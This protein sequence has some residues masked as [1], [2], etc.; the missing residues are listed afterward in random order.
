VYRNFEFNDPKSKIQLKGY[1]WDLQNPRYV[2][3]IIHGL[4]EL[5]GRYDRMND[6]LAKAGVAS[7][8]MDLRGHGRSGGVRGHCA[9]RKLV[10]G[11]IDRL[12]EKAQELYT[13][14]PMVFYGHS[15]GGN[16]AL[17]YKTRGRLN[18]VPAAYIISAPWLILKE[19]PSAGLLR[20]V[21]VLSKVAPSLTI[22]SAIDER[23]LGHPD[24]VKPYKD[25]P[26]VHDKISMLTAIEGL[27]IGEA[28]VNGTLEDNG[29]S[30]GKPWLLM[31][32]T[33]DK[34]CDIEGSRALY[35]RAPENCTFI[36]WE[37]L[38]H[39]IH[40]GN[41]TSRGD[42]VIEKMVAWIGEL[43]D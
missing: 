10:L 43:K 1:A 31:H 16:I 5:A 32:G 14:V 15:L 42:E 34:I 38:F 28:I 4:G 37:G 36:P 7:V 9:P 18:N 24:S 20:M 39:E 23:I 21:S 17:D 25:N 29:G 13:G 35:K 27:Q 2:M 26:L 6:Y 19:P 11:D 40:N 8:S 41:E 12:I 3:C 30:R 33:D 22:K